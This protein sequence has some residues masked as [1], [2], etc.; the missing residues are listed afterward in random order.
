MSLKFTVSDV[1]PATPEAI[2]DAWLDSRAHGKMTGA[3]A[4]A[5]AKVGGDFSV[6]DG[7]AIGK[8][9]ELDPGKRIVQ[10]WRTTDFAASDPD[11]KI[12][13][14]LAPVVVPEML[15]APGFDVQAVQAAGGASDPEG[16]G[17]VFDQRLDAVAEERGRVP[18]VERSEAHAVEAADSAVGPQPEV[19]VARLQ[20]RGHRVLRQVVGGGPGVDV[21][22]GERLGGIE[23]LGAQVVGVSGDES[24]TH[25]LFK[26][27]YGLKHTLLAD[28]KGEIAQLLGVPVKAGGKVRAT[29]PDRRPLLDA[30]GQRIDLER[31]ATLARWTLVVDRDGKIASLRSVANPV[32]DAEEVRKIVESLAK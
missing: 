29:G 10:S 22:L 30:N 25:K 24:A 9:L 3:K 18:G 15:E 2:Y 4:K 14:T 16:A 23:G 7:Y 6:W 20:D 8:N 5:S 28:P 27:T 31:P 11:S 13:V 26:E 32:T 1:I 17:L 21:V 12:T 19:A